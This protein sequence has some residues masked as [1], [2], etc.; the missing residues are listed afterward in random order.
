MVPFEP[1]SLPPKS[2]FGF[3]A[4]MPFFG[5]NS[6][7]RKKVRRILQSR[8]PFKDEIAV[9]W[10]SSHFPAQETRDILEC[11]R[12]NNGWPNALFLPFD[13][14]L[15]LAPFDVNRY[16]AFTA[17]TDTVNGICLILNPKEK[18]RL[19]SDRTI[20]GLSVRLGVRCGD[21]PLV[22]ASFITPEHTIADVLEMMKSVVK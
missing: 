5:A 9:M 7:F 8:S 1:I 22:D 12:V 13:P 3:F 2:A 21:V 14:F 11:I 10:S 19:K 6:R 20:G 18:E 17:D 16:D 4:T 15:A